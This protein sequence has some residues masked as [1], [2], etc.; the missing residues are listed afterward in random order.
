MSSEILASSQQSIGHNAVIFI[1][2]NI[3]LVVCVRLT[4]LRHNMFICELRQKI[5][6]KLKLT[7]SLFSDVIKDVVFEDKAKDKDLKP[8]PRPKNSKPQPKTSN[9]HYYDTL[10]S[11]GVTS[12]GF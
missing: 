6:A 9:C 1:S 10:P 5:N 7:G 11:T 8:R 3:V 4:K 12:I 2:L